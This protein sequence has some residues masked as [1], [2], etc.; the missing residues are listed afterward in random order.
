MQMR[1]RIPIIH[2][3]LAIGQLIVIG[4]GR[5]PIRI[6][7]LADKLDPFLSKLIGD[8][9]PFIIALTLDIL[10]DEESIPTSPMDMIKR[11]VIISTMEKPFLSVLF[12]IINQGLQLVLKN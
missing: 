10:N 1:R 8:Q 11:T 3:I 7:N 6:A 9:I 2:I 5:A 4:D 12:F